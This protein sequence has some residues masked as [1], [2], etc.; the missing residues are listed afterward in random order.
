[1]NRSQI[2][3]ALYYHQ[4]WLKG[5]PSGRRAVLE[6]QNLRGFYLAGIDLR[7]ARFDGSDLSFANLHRAKLA[8]ASFKNCKLVSTVFYSAD[9]SGA[10]L[11]CAF[12]ENADFYHANLNDVLVDDGTTYFNMACPETGSYIG[13][14]A[15][16][17]DLIAKLEIPEDALRCSATSKVCRASKAKC[18]ELQQL[19]GDETDISEA[20]S[21][22]YPEFIYRVGETVEVDDFDEDRWIELTTGIHHYVS[23]YDAVDYLKHYEGAKF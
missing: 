15:V 14:K 2:E 20:R 23:R 13:W 16:R 9:L 11:R 17:G 21:L 22:Y 8:G 5:D 6:D 3:T 18:L 4:L 7:Q 12:V 19:N 1:M 10:D